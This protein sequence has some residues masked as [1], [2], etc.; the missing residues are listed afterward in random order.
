MNQALPENRFLQGCFAPID[1]EYDLPT[2]PITGEVPRDLNGSFY[3]NGPN[4]KFAPR[5]DYHLFAGDGMTHAFHIE[6]GNVGYRNRWIQT[7]KFKLENELQRGVINP[8]NPF[9]CEEGYEEFVLTDKDGLANTACV[10]HAGKML[11]L[12]EGHP[13]FE[14][15]PVTLESIGSYNFGGKLTTAMTAHPKVDPKTGE[16]IFF[17]YMSSGPFEADI[18]LHK[19]SKDGE[20]TESL[21]IPTPY[22]AM[23]HDFVVTENYIIV[24]I[25]PLTGS[26]DRA[27]LGQAPFAW[28]PEKGAS[29]AVIPRVNATVESVRWVECDPFFVFHYMNGY[30]K[31]GVITLDGCQFDHAPLF[32]D[33]DGNMMEDAAPYLSRWNINLNDANA[34]V[35]S[36]RIDDVPSEFPQVDPRYAM[37]EYRYGFFNAPDGEGADMY[38]GVGRFDLS[39]NSVDRYSFGDR[40]TTFTSEAIFVPKSDAAAEGEGYLLSVVTDLPS[41]RSSLQILD[42][43][44]VS[45]GPLAVAQLPN[46]IPVGF[47]GGWRPA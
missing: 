22:S 29:V 17:A 38:N 24:P 10:W 16:L 12:E 37:Q 44:N 41:D 6:D 18:T 42:A 7:A 11:I 25:F 26:L 1:T 14:V 46:R 40:A 39:N 19:V 28:E 23:V 31:G 9:D 3:R 47:H 35:K 2:L 32:P 43:E 27:M 34:K 20:L 15:D 21:L 8:M 4:V 30:D 45:A 13:P 5:G 36:E 33:A